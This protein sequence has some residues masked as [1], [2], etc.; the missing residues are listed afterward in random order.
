MPNFRRALASDID[1]MQR[2][3]LGVLEN[4]LTITSLA[5]ADY[6]QAIECDGRGWVAEE[7]GAIVGFCI[8]V[9]PANHVW[10]LF[11]DP[12]YEGR[13]IGRCLLQTAVQWLEVSSDQPI[14]LTTEHGTRAAGFYKAAGWRHKGYSNDG[15]LVFEW[16]G[17]ITARR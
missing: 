7:N 17:T 11:V 9:K 4:K 12:N 6:V 2:I 13:G 15:E 14:W 1:A 16:P 5:P 3:R 8:A 10:A